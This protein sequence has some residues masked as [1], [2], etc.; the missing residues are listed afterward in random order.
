MLFGA[1][2]NAVVMLFLTGDHP[3]WYR[4]LRPN[5]QRILL[6]NV[7]CGSTQILDVEVVHLHLL[8][9][10]GNTA[11]LYTELLQSCLFICNGSQSVKLHHSTL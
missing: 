2:K 3:A 4:K 7:R 9:H 10:N 1:D 5:A 6:E 8:R 11:T